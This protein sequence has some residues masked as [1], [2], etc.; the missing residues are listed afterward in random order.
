M[1]TSR[2]AL[3]G[4][5]NVGRAFARLLL[6][7][8]DRLRSEYQVEGRVVA[9]FTARHGSVVRSSGINLPG[10]LDLSEA[11]RRLGPLGGPA[12]GLTLRRALLDSR[13]QVVLETTPLEP[14]SGQPAISH[15]E[16]RWSWAWMRSRRTRARW[17]SASN[18]WR[19]WRGAKGGAFFSSPRSWMELRCFPFSGKPCPRPAC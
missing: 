9:I 5:G 19:N 14:T 3:V 13:A 17:S 8:Q 6:A 2:I 16:P 11:G 10:A 7:Q 18:D 4:F 1:A 12:S 15:L